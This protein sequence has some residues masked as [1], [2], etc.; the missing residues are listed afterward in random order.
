MF[1]GMTGSGVFLD[2]TWEWNGTAWNE[3]MLP[4]GP[5]ARAGHTMLFDPIRQRVLL[6][7]GDSQVS[8]FADHWEWTGTGWTSLSSTLLPPARSNYGV[9]WNAPRQRAV[10]VGGAA[11]FSLFD[12]VWESSGPTWSQQSASGGPL[13]RLGHSLTSTPSGVLMFGGYSGSFAMKDLWRL[14]WDD[15]HVNE[16]CTLDADLDGDGLAGCADPDCW[17]ACSP[18]CPPGVSCAVSAPRCG[19]GV[20]NSAIETCRMCPSDCGGCPA[21]CGDNMCDSPETATSCPGDCP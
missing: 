11:Q 5:R 14:R 7:G 9:A 16:A 2:E 21:A 12:D 15:D 17:Y 13:P 4:L 8:T 6:L 3:H 10:Q 1:G 19:D 18:Q 20:C